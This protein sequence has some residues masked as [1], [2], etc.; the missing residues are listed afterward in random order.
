MTELSAIP[1]DMVTQE[2]ATQFAWWFFSGAGM[3]LYGVIIWVVKTGFNRMIDKLD[4]LTDKMTDQMIET[5]ELKV[6]LE[7]HINN[8]LIHNDRRGDCN[9]H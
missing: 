3:L 5:T 2:G 4:A 9:E 8:K 7:N 1:L 6:K